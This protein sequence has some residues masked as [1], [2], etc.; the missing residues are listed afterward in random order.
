M[1]PVQA[2]C[3]DLALR[4]LPQSDRTFS[5][6][7]DQPIYFSVH[8]RWADLAPQGKVLVHVA[9]YI[10]WGEETDPAKDRDELAR[11]IDVVQPE[12]YRQVEYERFMPRLTVTNSLAHAGDGGLAGRP[13]VNSPA[14]KNVYIAGDWVGDE[15]ML[16]DA[17][18]ASACRAA[19]LIVGARQLILEAQVV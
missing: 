18:F 4:S 2:A 16:S 11:F 6:G 14:A 13:G 10:P 7:V 1:K 17:A 12:W 3:L 15:G 5:I 9:K 19:Q 8:S